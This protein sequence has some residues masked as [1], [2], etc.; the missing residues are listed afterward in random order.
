MAE[1]D[2]T[3]HKSV[4]QKYGVRGYPTMNYFSKDN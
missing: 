2:C 3:I 4:C 1:V